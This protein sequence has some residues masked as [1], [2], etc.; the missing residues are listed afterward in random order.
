MESKTWVGLA[1]FD[2]FPSPKSQNQ[3]VAPKPKEVKSTVR[4]A[5]P[6]CVLDEKSAL[7]ELVFT[8]SS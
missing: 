7:N 2:V 8:V 5:H 6:D 3:L 1:E 4:G